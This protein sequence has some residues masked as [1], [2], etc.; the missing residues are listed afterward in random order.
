LRCTAAADA[1]YYSAAEQQANQRQTIT[2]HQPFLAKGEAEQTETEH[3][4]EFG[5]AMAA[6]R[7]GNPRPDV[8][9]DRHDHGSWAEAAAD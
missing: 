6:V 3:R 1:G 5:F 4:C 9:F 2:S 7:V 8:G